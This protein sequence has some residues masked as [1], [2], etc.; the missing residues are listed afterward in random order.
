MMH[1]ERKGR[2]TLIF[3]AL[4]LAVAGVIWILP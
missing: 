4:G 3:I 1:L 2:D